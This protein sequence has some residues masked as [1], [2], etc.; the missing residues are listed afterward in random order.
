MRDGI[1]DGGIFPGLWSGYV[2]GLCRQWRM[3]PTVVFFLA[4]GR[5]TLEIAI[6]FGSDGRVNKQ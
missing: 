4:F 1:T 3:H 6:F 5:A 2:E